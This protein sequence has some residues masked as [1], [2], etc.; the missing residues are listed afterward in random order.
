MLFWSLRKRLILVDRKHI[1]NNTAILVSGGFSGPMSQWLVSH[2]KAITPTT[3]LFID[4]CMLTVMWWQKHIVRLKK[5]KKVLINSRTWTSKL[6][7]RIDRTW[8]TWYWERSNV[9]ISN[10]LLGWLCSC[11]D[12][13]AQMR[14]FKF[15]TPGP[16]CLFPPNR[17]P[18]WRETWARRARSTQGRWRDCSPPWARWRRTC[19]S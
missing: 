9:C 10:S 17:C 3:N 8:R 18:P 19:P 5:T 14:S 2:E 12:N 4:V 15:V 13:D 11:F 6:P 7:S 1:F 16:P